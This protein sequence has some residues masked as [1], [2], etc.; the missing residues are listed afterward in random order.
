MEKYL[1]LNERELTVA[2]N[3]LQK[4]CKKV[5][6]APARHSP[7]KVVYKFDVSSVARVVFE[8]LRSKRI[9]VTSL[10][11]RGNVTSSAT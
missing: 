4:R 3:N 9:G 7:Y 1:V 6:C 10:T 2:L 5:N 8:I 11:F